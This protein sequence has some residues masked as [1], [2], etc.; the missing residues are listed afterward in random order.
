[1]NKKNHKMMLVSGVLV[2]LALL[3]GCSPFDMFK[4]RSEQVV[5]EDIDIAAP[6]TGD[7]L[8]TMKGVPIVTVDTLAV[9]KEKVLKANPQI[10]QAL[11]V[12]DPKPFERDLLDGLINQKIAAEYVRSQG[13]DQTD[14]YKKELKELY[15]AMENILNARYFNDMKKVTISDAEVRNFYEE[16]K[17]KMRGVMTSQGGVMAS[18]IE[19]DNEAAA[20]AF[21]T[22][23]KT[24]PGG[25]KKIAQDDN[26]NVQIKDFKLVNEQSVGIDELLRDKIVG[27]KTI[28]TIEVFDVNGKF[29][30]VN[31]T[32]KEEPKYLP[33]DQIKDRLKQ[34]LEQNKRVELLQQAIDE[35][36][37]QYAVEVNEDYFK[38]AEQA[39]QEMAHAGQQSGIANA[40]DKER[41]TNKRV[42]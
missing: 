17:D 26:L 24:A 3:P 14:A 40:V 25:F 9:E 7:V 41:T 8:V 21:A 6:M 12:M 23:A 31:A 32:V 16:H 30:V 28:P 1:M 35:L 29:W 10:R 27:M 18:G 4:S 15:E 11:A 2:T 39:S 20:R 33:Y 34:D 38:G 5:V 19:F 36:R 42:A 37:K 13:I 22:R